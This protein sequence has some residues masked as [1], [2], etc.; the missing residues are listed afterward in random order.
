MKKFKFRLQKVMELRR[1]LE[2]SSQQ[3][4]AKAQNKRKRAEKD[5]DETLGK[6]DHQN[7]NMMSSITGK[8]AA[9][10][11]LTSSSYNQSLRKEAAHKTQK[12]VKCEEIVVECRDDLI[13]KSRH[14]KV[15]ER[16]RERR[17]SGFIT[18]QNRQEQTAMDDD[19]ARHHHY[20]PVNR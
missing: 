16:L 3:R 1:W 2:R 19:A 7:R 10:E 14:K 15:L 17:I 11:A 4:L 6:I 12:V 8:F 5:L 20:N 18:E 9:G 13:E